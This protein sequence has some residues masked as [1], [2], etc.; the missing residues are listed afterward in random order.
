[1]PISAKLRNVFDHY[2]IRLQMDCYRRKV[3]E[4]LVA[5][6]DRTVSV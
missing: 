3:R 2:E 1:V 4:E 5:I 6:V